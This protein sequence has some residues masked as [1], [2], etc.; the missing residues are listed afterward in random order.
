MNR[1]D[2]NPCKCG[3]QKSYRS[4][5]CWNCRKKPVLSQCTLCNKKYY[6]KKSVNK[7]FCSLNCKHK[8]SS[9]NHNQKTDRGIRECK[10]CNRKQEV[11][12][13]LLN[14]KFCSRR[15]FYSFN[16][17]ENNSFWKG[18]ATQGRDKE[19]S[20]QKWKLCIKIVWKRDNATCQKCMEPFKHKPDQKFHVHHIKPFRYKIF[21]FNVNN[22][23]LLC[24]KCHRWVHSR[25]NTN[26]ELIKDDGI[27]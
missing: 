17:G 2:K 8:W 26:G 19:L 24:K 22:L 4:A 15:C 9:V 3:A 21:R 25:Y 12:R 1:V 5:T 6:H 14:R 7:K 11:R 18:G 27:Y 16:K 13:S 23:I 10:F 20:G